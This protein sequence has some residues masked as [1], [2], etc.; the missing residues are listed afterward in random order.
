MQILYV[1]ILFL[2][3]FCMDLFSL[4]ITSRLLSCGRKNYALLIAAVLGGI[5]SV[6]SVLYAGSAVVSLIIDV[7]ASVIITYIAF[8]G[9]K[10]IKKL[11]KACLLFYMVSL[12]IGGAV[13]A[14]Y[15][16]LN[17]FIGKDTVAEPDGLLKALI[18]IVLGA[19][20][21][22]CIKMS[23]IILKNTVKTKSVSVK[24]K[25]DNKSVSFDALVDSGNLL[26]DPFS[27]KSVIVVTLS[28]IEKVLPFDIRRAIKSK[29]YDISDI[30]V[31]NAKR[32]RLIPVKTVAGS[33]TLVGINADQIEITD[34]K[35]RAYPANA[36]IAVDS[37]TANDFSGYGAVM[38]SS[39][40]S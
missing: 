28:A 26:K 23:E 15:S 14:M 32:I 22:V 36:L 13:T 27:G 18:F 40:V 37:S 31:K 11:F 8:F 7:F 3:N 20:S 24:M 29:C 10:D 9:I 33:S 25:L 2:I 39:L 12:L 17:S 21:A 35:G 6:F 38:P 5:Y 19:I 1:D 34:E 30:S 16:F 4:Y